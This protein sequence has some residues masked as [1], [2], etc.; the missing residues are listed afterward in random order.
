MSSFM[1]KLK[2]KQARVFCMRIKTTTEQVL[3]AFNIQGVTVKELTVALCSF[4]EAVHVRTPTIL[5]LLKY[6]LDQ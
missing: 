5:V 3:N 2:S 6:Y 4:T 1:Q